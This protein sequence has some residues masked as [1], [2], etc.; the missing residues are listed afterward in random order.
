M[1]EFS[2]GPLFVWDGCGSCGSGAI[3]IS[4]IHHL[5]QRFYLIELKYQFLLSWMPPVYRIRT[6]EGK[7]ASR[8]R[9]S[10]T[11]FG[12]HPWIDHGHLLMDPGSSGSSGQRKLGTAGRRLWRSFALVRLWS[13]Q[14]ARRSLRLQMRWSLRHLRQ[15]VGL[16]VLRKSPPLQ[17]LVLVLNLNRLRLGRLPQRQA[18]HAPLVDC[19]AARPIPNGSWSAINRLLV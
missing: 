2:E 6:A 3:D 15:P 4:G 11:I 17:Y 9:F 19:G 8:L 18:G 13:C 14:T 10:T 12:I 16:L 7:P 1:F 5:T